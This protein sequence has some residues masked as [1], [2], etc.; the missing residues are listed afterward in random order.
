MINEKLRLKLRL[1]NT[2]FNVAIATYYTTLNTRRP[3][4]TFLD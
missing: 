1:F 4:Y 3:S 2:G